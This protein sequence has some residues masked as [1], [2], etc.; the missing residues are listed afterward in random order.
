MDARG[1]SGSGELTGPNIGNKMAV[2]LDEEVYTAPTL[3]GNISRNGQ[4]TGDFT[5]EQINYIIQVMTAGSLQ[6][7]LSPEPISQ[8][9][10][11]PEFGADN[12]RAG[13]T[14]ASGAGGAVSVFMVFYYFVFGGVAVISLLFNAVLIL[15]AMSLARA[16]FT[17]PGIAGVI[18]TFGMAVDANVLIYERV[19]EEQRKG[20]DLRPR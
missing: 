14:R 20:L 10:I 9:T 11:A 6:A 18:L 4:I 8:N 1:A 15:G 3:Q 16:A 12:L 13:R 17:L 2:L 5:P 19:R 7:N